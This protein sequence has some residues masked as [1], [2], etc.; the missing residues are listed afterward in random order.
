MPREWPSDVTALERL[1][2]AAMDVDPGFNDYSSLTV[3]EAFRA[4]YQRGWNDA[5]DNDEGLD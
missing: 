5:V 2:M 3:I 1:V 4:G